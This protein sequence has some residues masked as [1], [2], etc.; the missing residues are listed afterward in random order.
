MS[1]PAFRRLMWEY[2]IRLPLVVLL[3]GLWGFGL[4]AIFSVAD[5][6]TRTA[7]LTGNVATAFRLVGLDPL[8]A[9][10]A[11]GQ[12]HPVFLVASLLFVVGLGVQSVAGELESGSLDLTLARPI[13]R[14]R[15][16]GTYLALLVPGS[17]AIVLAYAVG[18]VAADRAFDPPGGPL[19]PGRMLIAAGESW[20][21]LLAIGAVA[22]L[23]SS[24]MS[25]RGR[26]LGVTVGIVLGMYVANFLFSLWGPMRPLT[27]VSLFR[28]FTPGPAIQEGSVSTGDSIVLA[29]FGAAVVVAALVWFARRD[30][31]R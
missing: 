14:R 5:P 9:W 24:L 13:G 26:A 27:R 31:S 4:V 11:I 17:A 23:V 20:L 3:V 28:Y 25:E 19:R 10:T 30:L 22:L 1:V 16:L 12:S 6:Q 2:R 21:L 29:L 15:Y 7:G 8:A 18:A